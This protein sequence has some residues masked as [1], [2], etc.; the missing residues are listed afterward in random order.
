MA[1]MYAKRFFYF[2]QQLLDATLPPRC[3]ISGDLVEQQGMV[4]P[5]AWRGLNFIVD[6]FCTC[7]G[8]PFAHEV[9]EGALCAPCLDRPPPFASNRSALIYN[10]A[11]R[12]LVLGFKYADKT[13]MVRA[14]TP[15]LRRAG[16]DMIKEADFIM[17]VP[18]HY[19]RLVS[20]RYNQ[21]GLMASA[22]GKATM[23]PVLLNGL[24]RVRATPTQG[25][26]SAKERHKNVKKAFAVHR[27]HQEAIKGKA[28]ILID[29]VYTTGA[30]LK[31]CTK[32]LLK[33]GA[34]RVET[35][36]LVRTTRDG[37]DA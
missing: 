2:A 6:P 21:S 1:L 23:L 14:F 32:V 27:R 20:R 30:T 31:E 24:V 10:E 7:C 12:G 13:H 16:R 35:L 3:V 34:K 26:L 28:I 17:P 22:L 4:S 25:R 5:E 15:W 8:L 19:W 9:D 36:T 18:L 11:S 37:F 29:D 33:G